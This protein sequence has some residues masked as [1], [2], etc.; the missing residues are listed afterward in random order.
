LA[1]FS[2]VVTAD[3]SQ[4]SESSRSAFTGARGYGLN[5]LRLVA[6]RAIAPFTATGLLVC[7]AWL[8]R[9]DLARRIIRQA[10]PPRFSALAILA[11]HAWIAAA[12]L[13]L[14]ILAPNSARFGYDAAVHAI[15]IGFVLSMVFAHA[16]IIL[17][18]VS[19]CGCVSAPRATCRSPC[20]I[21]P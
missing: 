12:G 20:C 8:A 7:A 21:C 3:F 2:L 18:A 15:A 19:D 14:L 9:H 4:N 17:P 5:D 11:G 13:V 10:G 16:P 1:S 6:S